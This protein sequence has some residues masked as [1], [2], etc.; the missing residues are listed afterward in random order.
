MKKVFFITI[1]FFIINLSFA[2]KS[3]FELAINKKAADKQLVAKLK[4]FGKSGI[5]KNPHVGDISPQQLIDTALTYLGTPHR[6]GGVSHRGIDCSG[7]LYMSFKRLGLK[8]P[9]SS[10]G[11]AHYGKVI[12]E[13]DSLRAGDLVFF[14]RTYRTSKVITHT[15]IYIGDGYFVHTSARRGVVKAYIKDKYYLKHYVFATRFWANFDSNPKEKSDSE[16]I[17]RKSDIAEIAQ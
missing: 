3:N 2:Q 13:M 14:T 4:S 7:L 15:G 10:Q 17:Y 5:E 8:V 16:K 1:L 6:M 9:R 12:V 11:L